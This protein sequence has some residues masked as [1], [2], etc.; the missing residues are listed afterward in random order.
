M[1]SGFSRL[2]DGQ[3]Q[4]FDSKN[5][6]T[7]RITLPLFRY[8]TPHQRAAVYA[9][10]L[11]DLG[12]LPGTKAAAAVSLLPASGDWQ[13][14]GFSTETSGLSAR[15]AKL[16]ADVESASTYYFQTIGI[17]VLGGREF[18]RQDGED[19]Q[20]VAVISKGLA[21]HFWPGQDPIGRRLKLGPP[22]STDPWR[23]II[24]IVGDVR[25]FMFDPKE[26][27]KIYVPS[28]QSPASSMSLVIRTRRD[29]RELIPSVRAALAAIDQKLLVTFVRSM[30]EFIEEESAGTSIASQ[31]MG[32]FG[33]VALV[34]SAIGIYSLMA[35]STSQRTHEMGIRMALGAERGDVM[36]IVLRQALQLGSTGVAIG[37][38]AALGLTRLLA[39]FLYGAVSAD[40]LNL[41][42]TSTALGAVVMA[43]S[44]IPAR[45]ATAV[46]PA[47]TLHV[48]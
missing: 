6:L 18:K 45:R 27:P 4:G 14:R 32:S 48:E 21:T 13:N 47:I 34:L 39:G 10:I 3:R 8:Q 7:M 46:D 42:L 20:A 35:Y 2:A 15:R 28:S 17:P 43:A 22:D 11:D 37:V 12:A 26:P 25:Q 24:G 38:A 33:L 36:W 30:D 44:Y 29:P 19:T 31:L 9:R 40:A 5:V 1:V 41:G 23:T 16:F